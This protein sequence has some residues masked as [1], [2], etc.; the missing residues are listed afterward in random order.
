MISTA[1]PSNALAAEPPAIVTLTEGPGALL[2]GISR[3]ALA[4]KARDP[5]FRSAL[6][7]NLRS[8]PEWDPILFP[9]KYKPKPPPEEPEP[10]AVARPETSQ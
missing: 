1:G 8:H 6:I 7:A 3:Y 9:E 2:R 4:P 5:A 10:P